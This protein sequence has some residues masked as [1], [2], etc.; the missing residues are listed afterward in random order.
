MKKSLLPLMVVLSVSLLATGCAN[1]ADKT[2]EPQQTTEEGKD[3]V[4]ETVKDTEDEARSINYQDIKVTPDQAFDK[5][6]ELHPNTQ[7][8]EIDLDKE[9]TEYQYVVEGHDDKNAY[10]VKINPVDGEIISDDEELFSEEEERAEITKGHLAKVDS[11][12]EKAKKEDGSD[13]ELDEWNIS[14]EDGKVVMDVEIGLMKYSYD[15]DSEKLTKSEESKKDEEDKDIKEVGFVDI[16]DENE[17]TQE[18]INNLASKDIM[19]GITETEFKPSELMTRKDVAVTMVKGFYEVDKDAK[20]SFT[21]VKEDD[22][23]YQY[24]ATA[25]KEEI[26]EGYPNDLFEGKDNIK[27]EA[28]ISIA[29]RLLNEKKGVA[30]PENPKDVIKSSDKD[31]ITE[32]AVKEIALAAKEGIIDNT[33]EKLNPQSNITRAEAALVINRLMEKIK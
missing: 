6:M 16:G 13:S 15:I 28:L 27:K 17:Q 32:Y 11:I 33:D 8:K 19:D 31:E 23:N 20:A 29:S 4:D 22:K 5:F 18:A 14:S 24:I 3:V 21:D 2:N 10:E 25:E 12:I 26:I 7:I 9:L 30:Y 1:D